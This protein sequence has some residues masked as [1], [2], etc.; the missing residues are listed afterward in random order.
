MVLERDWTIA[1]AIAT[2]LATKAVAPRTGTR[3]EFSHALLGVIKPAANKSWGDVTMTLRTRLTE[4]LRIEH[5]VL[6]AV[7]KAH[8][9]AGVGLSG[10][11]ES[12]RALS[13]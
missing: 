9:G 5:P 10:A 3:I 6:L 4:K 11:V 1:I 2:P 7:L 12:R 8:C 13:F